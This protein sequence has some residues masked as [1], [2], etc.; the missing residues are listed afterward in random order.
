MDD[1]DERRTSGGA[2][3]EYN[4]DHANWTGDLDAS[5]TWLTMPEAMRLKG[6]RPGT[7][8]AS[9]KGRDRGTVYMVIEIE[10]PFS[11][12]SDGKRRQWPDRMKKKRL[13][14]LTLNPWKIMKEC[15][16]FMKNLNILISE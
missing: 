12:C 5:V 11:F 1:C 4:S 7:I 8:A 16:L 6:F 14:Y 2:L 15:F 13:V 10:D 9:K 3:R